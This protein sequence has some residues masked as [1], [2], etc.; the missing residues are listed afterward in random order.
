MP[1]AVDWYY[2]VPKYWILNFQT[3]LFLCKCK[4]EHFCLKEI[5]L[6]WFQ[7]WNNKQLLNSIMG[8]GE[9]MWGSGTRRPFWG[10]ARI[11]ALQRVHSAAA[12]SQ[13]H[14]YSHSSQV[15][16]L[17]TVVVAAAATTTKGEQTS[18][19]QQQPGAISPCVG[20]CSLWCH[21]SY[22]WNVK[23]CP[24]LQSSGSKKKNKKKTTG[25]KGGSEHTKITCTRTNGD[26]FL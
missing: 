17:R 23:M 21:K 7:T 11:V 8:G 20:T 9:G 5:K 13:H 24:V 18:P 22:A 4:T 15:W 10:G 14:S 25:K 12:A 1:Y 2:K 3:D 6:S 26:L 16:L 19:C